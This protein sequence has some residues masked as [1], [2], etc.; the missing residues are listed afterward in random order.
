MVTL[1]TK[2]KKSYGSSSNLNPKN[3]GGFIQVKSLILAAAIFNT[4]FVG[5]TTYQFFWASIYW[6]RVVKAGLNLAWETCSFRW[7]PWIGRGVGWSPFLFLLVLLGD[8]FYRRTGDE[9]EV[10]NNDR[11]HAPSH[12]MCNKRREPFLKHLVVSIP[13]G[14]CTSHRYKRLYHYWKKRLWRWFS[15]YPHRYHNHPYIYIVMIS[16]SDILEGIT[17]DQTWWF[18]E[19]MTKSINISRTLVIVIVLTI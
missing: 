2:S 18:L 10:G 14:W 11:A 9:L 17:L 1:C 7:C 3:I 4:R 12:D 5:T 15:Y 8:N 6:A 13:Y 19:M 16:R